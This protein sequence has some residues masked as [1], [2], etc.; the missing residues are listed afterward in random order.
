MSKHPLE[1]ATMQ[2]ACFVFCVGLMLMRPAVGRPAD[3]ATPVESSTL[4]VQP[5][6]NA[7]VLFD[8]SNLDAWAKQKTKDWE[9]SDGPA[10]WKI[11]SDG[12][13]EVVPGMNCIITKKKFSDFKLHIEFRLLGP[14]TNG[15]IFLM[16]RYEL[17]INEK[18]GDA[19]GTPCG[20]FENV[21]PAIKPSKIA[22]LPPEQW[23]TFDVDFR[24]PRLG[25]DGK[26]T[27]N[28]RATVKFNGI[29][30]HD[31]VELGER[32]GASKRLPDV[33]SAPLMLQEH[34]TAYQ[35]RNIWI[36]EQ[37]N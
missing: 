34:G 19:E 12:V 25:A 28:A 24:A 17:G 18:F 27:E 13:L 16:T 14:K 7:I 1:R 9:A 35:F 30:I 4:N 26:T 10:A 6:K 20:T 33:T 8:G 22:A 32:K 31:N 21:V 11:L 36:V 5:P 3:A 15:G 37:N 2:R 23:Q 29:L